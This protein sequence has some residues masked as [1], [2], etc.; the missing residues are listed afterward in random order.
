MHYLEII[1]NAM[2][3]ENLALSYLLGMCTFTCCVTSPRETLSQADAIRLIGQYEEQVDQEIYG[4]A[5]H[6]LHASSMTPYNLTETRDSFI[7]EYRIKAKGM[8]SYS[9]KRFKVNKKTKQVTGD[10][11]WGLHR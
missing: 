7:V 5:P 8:F 3:A 1:L 9:A 2:F 10:R 11:A 4:D 6:S